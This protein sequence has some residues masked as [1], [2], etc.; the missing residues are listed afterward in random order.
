MN[1]KTK[2]V[3]KKAKEETPKVEEKKVEDVVLPGQNGAGGDVPWGG[4]GNFVKKPPE[5]IPPVE[6]KEPEIEDVPMPDENENTKL[7]EKLPQ[8]EHLVV[9]SENAN[10]FAELITSHRKEGWTICGNMVV[11]TRSHYDNLSRENSYTSVYHILLE[12]LE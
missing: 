11:N 7:E 12:R 3:V 5:T 4:G 8:I 10:D 6:K 1:A 2:K 9:E